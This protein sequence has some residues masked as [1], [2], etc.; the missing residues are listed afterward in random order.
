MPL[1]PATLL[2][3]NLV[4][5]QIALVRKIRDHTHEGLDS[6]PNVNYP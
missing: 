4:P 6:S 5:G 1:A 3:H 2:M